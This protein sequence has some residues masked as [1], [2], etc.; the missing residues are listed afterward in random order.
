MGWIRSGEEVAI[1][2]SATLYPC[3]LKAVV[4]RLNGGFGGGGGTYLAIT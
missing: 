4:G 1:I 3:C 2:L